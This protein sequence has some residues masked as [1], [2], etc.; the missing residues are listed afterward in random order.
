M[1]QFN[2]R[3]DP[4]ATLQSIFWYED[5]WHEVQPNMQSNSPTVPE[6]HDKNF[7][8]WVGYDNKKN[9]VSFKLGQATCT[10]SSC[11]RKTRT[12]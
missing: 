2:Y 3:F 4:A 12:S 1:Q 10:M 8:S 9:P 7:R 5:S 11:T 6:L